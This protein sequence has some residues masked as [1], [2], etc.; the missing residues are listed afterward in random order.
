MIGLTDASVA[1]GRRI[2]FSGITFSVPVGRCMA[3]LGPN[4]RGKTTLASVH[5]RD[6]DSR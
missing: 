2:L 6:T 4:G 1:F 3:I 5:C